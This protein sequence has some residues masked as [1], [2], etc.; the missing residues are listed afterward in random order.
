MQGLDPRHDG[1][2]IAHLSDIHVGPRTDHA[3]AREA[4]GLAN[5]SGAD[6]IALTGDYVNISRRDIPV[7]QRVLAGLTGAPV[8]VTLGNHDYYAGGERVAR[9]MLE[10]G[11]RV[12][13]NE[14][15]HLDVNGAPLHVIGVDDPVT[16]RHDLDAAFGPVNDESPQHGTRLVLCHGPELAPRIAA[17]GAHLILSGHTHATQ[18][19]VGG[20]GA[21]IAKRIGLRY[22]AGFYEIGAALLYVTAGIGGSGLQV[23]VGHGTRAE[24][25]LLTLRAA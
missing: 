17:R 1:V 15:E 4:V 3:H 18:I 10:N 19:N 23:R 11:Y 9:A 24:V 7:M 6:L 12:L 8:Y 16:R 2:R 25:A 22:I 20:L 14:R 5:E 21:R 13:R